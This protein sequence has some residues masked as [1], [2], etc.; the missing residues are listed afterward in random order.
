MAHANVVGKRMGRP[1]GAKNKTRRN[2]EE[3]LIKMKCDPITGLARLAMDESIH[4]EL[5]VK[6]YAALA[7]YI[8]PKKASIV[9]RNDSAPQ[10]SFVLDLTGA[11]VV[12]NSSGGR[13]VEGE[14]E[15]KPQL[16]I[17]Q[18]IEAASRDELAKL[19]DDPENY[20]LVSEDDAA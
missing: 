10:T 12:A 16:V 1:P 20:E 7:P 9:V 13:T 14:L 6:A 3:L 15:P 19:V 8:Y 17:P 11:K 5:R 4:A 18:I 2:V